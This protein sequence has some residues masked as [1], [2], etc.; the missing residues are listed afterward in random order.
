MD[1]PVTGLT[2][3]GA[4]TLISPF[5]HLCPVRFKL[6]ERRCG[7]MVDC[8]WPD[9][10]QSEKV[11]PAS[12]NGPTSIIPGVGLGSP[13]PPPRA[14]ARSP[15]HCRGGCMIDLLFHTFWGGV[16]ATEIVHVVGAVMF[17]QLARASGRQ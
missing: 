1:G 15:T 8:A 3:R 7:I 12:D 13:Y 10:R 2:P 11:L 17:L 9:R 16:V 5:F 14:D 6:F 4:A